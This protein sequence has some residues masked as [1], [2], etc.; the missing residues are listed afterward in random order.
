M[1]VVVVMAGRAEGAFGHVE[2]AELDRAGGIEALER[3]RGRW[4]RPRRADLAPCRLG[5]NALSIAFFSFQPRIAPFG[6]AIHIGIGAAL[7]DKLLE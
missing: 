6:S 1:S 3:S 4:G 2:D 7:A 5:V